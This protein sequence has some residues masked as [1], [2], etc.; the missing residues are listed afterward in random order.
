M[1]RIKDMRGKKLEK[2]SFAHDVGCAGELLYNKDVELKKK[3][4]T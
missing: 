4:K 1:K 2:D 3:R